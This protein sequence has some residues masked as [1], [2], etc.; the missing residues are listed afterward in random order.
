VLLNWRF[1]V[2]EKESLT[3]FLSNGI[4]LPSDTA[5]VQK[6]FELDALTSNLFYKNSMALSFKS[7]LLS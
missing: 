5:K 2:T 7:L 4:S 6:L 3:L 1:D